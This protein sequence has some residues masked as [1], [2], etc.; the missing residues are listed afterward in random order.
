[1]QESNDIGEKIIPYN[2]LFDEQGSLYYWKDMSISIFECLDKIMKNENS[3]PIWYTELQNFI[4]ICETPDKILEGIYVNYD[5][6]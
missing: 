1:M 3:K 5:S 4:E 6:Y 2:N